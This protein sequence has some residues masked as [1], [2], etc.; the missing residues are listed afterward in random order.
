MAEGQANSS[1]LRI[2]I[3][4]VPPL[5]FSVRSTRGK[6]PC[7]SDRRQGSFRSGTNAF[8]RIVVQA[9]DQGLL[10]AAIAG[11]L[12]LIAAF[13]WAMALYDWLTS[14]TAPAAA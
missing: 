8:R 1:P 5:V 7:L 13:G 14:R 4:T 10:G 6:L 2:R 11:V 12:G 9:D 3:S